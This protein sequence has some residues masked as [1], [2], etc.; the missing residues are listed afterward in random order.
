[1]GWTS[2]PLY[3]KT[4]DYFERQLTWESDGGKQEPLL[5]SIVKRQTLY[6]AVRYT[7]KPGTPAYEWTGGKPYVFAV[8][9][10]LKYMPR[11]EF[12]FAYKDMDETCGPNERECPRKIL[13]LLTPLEEYLS[14]DSMGYK[15]AAE[16]RQD[17]WKR[18]QKKGV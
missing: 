7:P 2:M 18:F 15:W 3:G 11:S 16:W 6:A 8:I 14:T 4:R 12:N 5:I 13:E 17:C 1:M 9:C 10:L